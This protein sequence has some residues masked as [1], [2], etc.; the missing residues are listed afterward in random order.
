[1]FAN[2]HPYDANEWNCNEESIRQIGRDTGIGRGP[3]GGK[4]GKFNFEG[5]KPSQKTIN[6]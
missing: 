4:G 3:E 6:F 1:M 2:S 5:T